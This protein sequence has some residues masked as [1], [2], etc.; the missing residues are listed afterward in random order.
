M[1]FIAHLE[2]QKE[3]KGSNWQHTFVKFHIDGEV[4]EFFKVEF[5]KILKILQI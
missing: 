5:N 1:E 2:E 3:K 4:I